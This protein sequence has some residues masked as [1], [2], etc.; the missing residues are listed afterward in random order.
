MAESP[1][2]QRSHDSSELYLWER[3]ASTKLLKRKRGD[4]EKMKKISQ[5]LQQTCK[6]INTSTYNNFNQSMISQSTETVREYRM[7]K[8]LNTCS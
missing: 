3:G 4:K 1:N 8:N 2:C 5:A 6:K 7:F